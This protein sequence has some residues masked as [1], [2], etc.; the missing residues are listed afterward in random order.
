[1]RAYTI[2]RLPLKPGGEPM[3]EGDVV[4]W[5]NEKV[6]SK[7]NS[8]RVLKVWFFWLYV[9]GVTIFQIQTLT[10]RYLTFCA[11]ALT[12]VRTHIVEFYYATLLYSCTALRCIAWHVITLHYKYITSQYVTS[13]RSMM[14]WWGRLHW[15]FHIVRTPRW[16]RFARFLERFLGN[17][18]FNL[19]NQAV[20]G[21]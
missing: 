5:V 12:N 6:R 11:F 3:K 20:Y 15:A 10:L 18:Y 21:I 8:Y 4:A 7:T 14:G 16:Y 9:K 13:K 1:M 17:F 19:Q 2:S